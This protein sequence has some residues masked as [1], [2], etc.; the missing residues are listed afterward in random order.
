M[1]IRG[2]LIE[3]LITTENEE[4]LKDL[5]KI[6]SQ[7]P[8]FDTKN[9]LGDYV[10][11]FPKSKTYTDIKTKIM[12]L[13]SN[14]KAYNIDKFLECMSEDNSVFMFFFVGINEDQQ[15]NSILCSVYDKRL[16]DATVLQF[17]WAGRATRGVAQ[18]KGE[19]I[20]NIILD[21]NFKHDID[22]KQCDSF[23]EGLLKR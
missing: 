21:T 23:I 10:R 8:V 20:S 19:V 1:N 6:E 18:F 12:Y 9:G 15:Y 14:P 11:T 17:H 2:R 13:S 4:I 22:S 7:L 5:K 16:I 3:Y